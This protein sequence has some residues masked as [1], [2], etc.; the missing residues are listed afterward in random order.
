MEQFDQSRLESAIIFADRL[1]EGLD[2]ISGMLAEE[3]SALNDPVVIRSMYF[4]KEVLQAVHR[5]SGRVSGKGGKKEFPLECLKN[6]VYTGDK[7]ITKFLEQ[8]KNLA[9]DPD[10]KGISSKALGDWLKNRG[11][12]TEEVNAYTGKRET[13]TTPE[14]EDFGIYTE[15]RTSFYGREYRVNLYS[16]KAQEY[17]VENMEAIL[18]GEV[19]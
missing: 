6:F 8:L 9:D 18:N 15:Q 11:Y 17:I 14:G 10:V 1:A 13:R 2:P 16:R 7:P 4:I 12:L 5:N 19:I 3:D